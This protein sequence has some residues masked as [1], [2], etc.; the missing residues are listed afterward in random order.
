MSNKTD[1]IINDINMSEDEFY[2]HYTMLLRS[3]LNY[4]K[5]YAFYSYDEYYELKLRLSSFNTEAMMRDEIKE[6]IKRYKKEM[7]YY[8]NLFKGLETLQD[9]EA[10]T[11]NINEKFKVMKIFNE[12]V[13]K[14]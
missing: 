2:K 6:E 5:L 12:M 1:L 10:N 11:T 3:A 14:I 4:A 8:K 7:E 13:N 9:I